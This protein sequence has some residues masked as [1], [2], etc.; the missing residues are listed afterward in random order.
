MENVSNSDNSDSNSKTSL[1]VVIALSLFLVSTEFLDIYFSFNQLKSDK[2]KYDKILFEDCI[3]YNIISQIVFTFFA[4]LAGISALLLGA[5]LLYDSEF[6]SEKLSRSYL[7]LNYVIF[8]P[9]LL[10]ASIYGIM[11]FNNIVFTCNKTLDKKFFNV[12]NL[13]SLIICFILSALITLSFSFLYSIKFIYLSVRLKR[14]GFKLLGKF[15]WYYVSSSSRVVESNENNN[16]LEINNGVLNEQILEERLDDI[17]INDISR[18]SGPHFIQN[19]NE[20]ENEDV[21][22]FN[23]NNSINDETEKDSEYKNDKLCELLQKIISN[24]NT[25]EIAKKRAINALNLRKKLLSK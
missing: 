24:D 16:N 23:N 9:Y 22:K 8:G 25:T 4:A 10:T 18:I 1:K 21:I 2:L 19:E 14:G 11:Y 17:H 15:F 7:Y 13:M 5:G 3:Q 12:S 6:F 20:E